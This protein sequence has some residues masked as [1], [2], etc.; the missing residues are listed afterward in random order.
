MISRLAA[1][2]RTLTVFG[3]MRWLVD[4]GEGTA[5]I[6]GGNGTIWATALQIGE[7]VDTAERVSYILR[8]SYSAAAIPLR[9]THAD[10]STMTCVTR[11]SILA[12]LGYWLPT[13][14]TGGT[15]FS[16]NWPWSSKRI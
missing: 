14:L 1:D 16:R 4:N 2:Q 8:V 10:C 6:A 5:T 7:L 12:R 15:D 11:S 3:W 13:G 9:G